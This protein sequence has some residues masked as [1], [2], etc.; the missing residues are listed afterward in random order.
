VK[1]VTKLLQSQQ[2]VKW[3]CLQFGICR[4]CSMMTG[5]QQCSRSSSFS[6]SFSDSMIILPKYSCWKN[7]WPPAIGHGFRLKI[8]TQPIL[9]FCCRFSLYQTPPEEEE[10]GTSSS[11][12]WNDENLNL[13]CQVFWWI[14][15]LKRLPTKWIC[16]VKLG[17]VVV[18]YIRPSPDAIVWQD[19]HSSPSRLA[20]AAA[21]AALNYFYLC[22]C[23]V[24]WSWFVT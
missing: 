2:Q 19:C 10:A 3:H 14:F 1:S 7:Y 13:T 21:A 12:S 15:N 16:L 20:V 6:H 18:P 11:G 17:M 9:T 4:P 22:L 23:I 8:K 5:C 24:Y